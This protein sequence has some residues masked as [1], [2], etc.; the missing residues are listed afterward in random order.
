MVRRYRPLPRY[1]AV[2]RDLAIVAPAGTTFE[3]IDGVIRRA[4]RLPIADVQVF[5]RY[6]GPGIP[7]GC[8]SLAVQIMFQHPERTL[9]T[10]EVQESIEAITATLSRELLATLR[11]VESR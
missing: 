3:A 10:Q 6:R 9:T 1:P 7:A 2:R 11:G 8:A 4:S 5:D